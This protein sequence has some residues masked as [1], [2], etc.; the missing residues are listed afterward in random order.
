MLFGIAVIAGVKG[1]LTKGIG[2][3]AAQYGDANTNE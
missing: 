2:I 1:G 3:G